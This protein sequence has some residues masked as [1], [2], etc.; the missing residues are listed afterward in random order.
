MAV[1]YSFQAG[2]TFRIPLLIIDGNKGLAKNVR[3]N[4]KL[5]TGNK[6]IPP[7]TTPPAAVFNVLESPEGWILEVPANITATLK[8][9][10]YVVNAAMEVSGTTMIT[11]PSFIKVEGTTVV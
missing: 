2:E 6:N 10:L 1:A 11:D 9:G 7:L 3:A 8:P 5:T 4:L